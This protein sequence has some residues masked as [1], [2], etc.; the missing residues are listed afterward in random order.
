MGQLDQSL[1]KIL[2][3]EEDLLAMKEEI[4]SDLENYLKLGERSVKKIT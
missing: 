4:E 1:T 3:A 2:Q